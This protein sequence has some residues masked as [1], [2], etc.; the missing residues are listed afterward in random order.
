[1]WRLWLLV[2]LAHSQAA[3]VML[4][5]SRYADRL[6]IAHTLGKVDCLKEI[7][8]EINKIDATHGNG[9]RFY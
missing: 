3:C 7:L 9:S 1:M 5:K 4:T 8:N 6:K 2:V